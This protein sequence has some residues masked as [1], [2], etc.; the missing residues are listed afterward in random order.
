MATTSLGTAGK[1][2]LRLIPSG[3][4]EKARGLE[5]KL[6]EADTGQPPLPATHGTGAWKSG[7]GRQSCPRRDRQ[8]GVRWSPE[9]RNA[10]EGTDG[11]RDLGAD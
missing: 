7:G 6:G 1:G 4:E 2:N 5:S 9:H 10:E 8:R 3:R 11:N